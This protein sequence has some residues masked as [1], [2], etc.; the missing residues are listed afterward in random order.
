MLTFGDIEAAITC[1]PISAGAA[2]RT[3]RSPDL[4]VPDLSV[5]V[6]VPVAARRDQIA[7]TLTS[8]LAQRQVSFELLV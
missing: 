7:A 2:E 5:I 3:A 1:L 6:L 8:L 4:S